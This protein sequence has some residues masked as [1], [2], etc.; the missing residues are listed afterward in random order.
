[1]VQRLGTRSAVT[2]CQNTQ[3][4]QSRRKVCSYSLSKHSN[5]PERRHKVCSYSLS[6]IQM[7]QREGTRSVFVFVFCFVF[8]LSKHSNGPERRHDIHLGPDNEQRLNYATRK[9][10]KRQEQLGF[11]L[12]GCLVP[13]ERVWESYNKKRLYIYVC[14]YGRLGLFSALPPLPPPPYL[15]AGGG[16]GWGGAHLK[17]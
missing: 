6:N 11:V 17:T 15:F 5:G 4:V 9:Q 1:M 3:T 16:V 12:C 8:S 14:I 2:A 7:V 13:G 10:V